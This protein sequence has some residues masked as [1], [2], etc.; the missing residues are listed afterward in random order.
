MPQDLFRKSSIKR[1]S[2]PD[3]LND[4]LKVARPGIWALVIGIGAVIA[5]FAAW[6]IFGQILETV[7]MP[8]T[9]LRGSDN[10]LMVHSYVPIK[11]G[12]VIEP[13][14]AAR[15]SPDFAPSERYGYLEG[16]VASVSDAPVTAQT[17]QAQ[18]GDDADLIDLPSDGN[19]I[20]IVVEVDQDETGAPIWSRPEGKEVNVPVG[21]VGTVSVVTEARNPLSIFF[22]RSSS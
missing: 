16:E 17:V 11:D 21:S 8:G 10:S 20:E 9:V 12:R 19:L 3:Q 7:Q 22:S 1:I 18:L 14:M 5:G 15:V 4:Y 6:G 13:G 2:S